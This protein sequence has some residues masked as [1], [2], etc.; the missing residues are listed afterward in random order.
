[1]DVSHISNRAF[2]DVMDIAERPVVASHSDSRRICRHH[3]NLTDEQFKALCEL[4]GCAGINLFSVF[5]SENGNASL[6]DVYRHMDHFLSL[7]GGGHVS[8]GGDL[9]GCERLP[10]GFT[11]LQDYEK[12]IGFL[13]E[14]RLSEES[15]QDIFSK[16]LKKVVT[17]CTT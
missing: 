17:L 15:I 8:L 12:L 11:G 16:T 14:K 10:E 2:W 9:D 6:E 4:G 5:L 3:R 1:M 7:S 13:K